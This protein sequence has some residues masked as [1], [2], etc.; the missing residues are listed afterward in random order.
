MT[1]GRRLWP[2]Q[3]EKPPSLANHIVEVDEAA[4]LS[5]NVEQIT[6]LAGRCVGLMFNCT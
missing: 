2:G 6:V 5:D 3:T 4:A 1:T